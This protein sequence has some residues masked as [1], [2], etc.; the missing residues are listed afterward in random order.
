MQPFYLAEVEGKSLG[1]FYFILLLYYFFFHTWF[2]SSWLRLSNSETF[3]N[4]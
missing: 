3:S 2:F 4:L 1:A